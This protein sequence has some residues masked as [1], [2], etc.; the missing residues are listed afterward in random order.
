LYERAAGC[1][2]GLRRVARASLRLASG[3]H[4]RILIWK[5]G[6]KMSQLARSV[7]RSPRRTRLIAGVVLLALAALMLVWIGHATAGKGGPT[8]AVKIA[9]TVSNVATGRAD[10]VDATTFVCTTGGTFTDM[11]EMSAT[12]RL[13]GRAAQPVIVLFEG[14]WGGPSFTEGTGAFIRLA[15]D[16]VVQTPVDVGVERRPTGT[17]DDLETHGFN[18]V[19]DPLAPGTHTATI[20]WRGTTTSGQVCV[21]DRSMIVLHK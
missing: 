10:A 5:G 18:F 4:L 19:S 1:I 8:R 14:E 11:P 20:Q 13:G 15:I 3:L 7:R 12:F 2:S 6:E 9:K 16:G 21:Q 17:P